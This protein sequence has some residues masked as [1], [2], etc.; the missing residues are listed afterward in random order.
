MDA[1]Q[2]VRKRGRPDKGITE[3]YRQV[4]VRLAPEIIEQ[5]RRLADVR[6]QRTGKVTSQL[7]LIR[8]AIAEYLKREI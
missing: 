4:Y 5:L 7:D 3:N 2:A 1:S 6:Q 8:E